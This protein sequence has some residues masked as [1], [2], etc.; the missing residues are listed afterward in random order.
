VRTAVREMTRRTLRRWGLHAYTDRSL[1]P[2]VDWLHDI[3][4]SGVLPSSPLCFDVGANVGQTVIALRERFPAAVV[5]SFEP[6]AQ[7]FDTLRTL[8]AGLPRTHARQLALGDTPGRMQAQSRAQSVF[9]SLLT[10]TPADEPSSAHA[11]GEHI[12]IET[13]DRYCAAHGIAHIDLLKTDTEGF[14][15]HVLRG[16]CSLFDRAAV[17]FVYAEVSFDRGNRQNTPAAPLFDWMLSKDYCCLGLYET[18]PLHRF[19][20]PNLFCNALFVSRSARRR[21]IDGVRPE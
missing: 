16:G 20:E 6:F 2:G 15:L 12:E 11:H 21:M 7:P 18:Y 14:D 5:H 10:A 19:A 8:C 9:N 13:L 3:A 4:R 1:P 17:T